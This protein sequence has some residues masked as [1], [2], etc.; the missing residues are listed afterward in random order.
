[1]KLHLGCGKRYIPGFFHMDAVPFAHL[2]QQGDIRNL[3]FLASESVDLIYCC[4][5]FEY[6]D[7]DEARLTLREWRRVLKP[8]GVLRLAVPD[9]EALAELYLELRDLSRVLGP[10]YGRIAANDG[11]FFHK[12]A[13]DFATLRQILAEEGFPGGDRY[14]WRAVEHSSVDDFSQAYYPHMEKNHGKLLSLNVEAR[15]G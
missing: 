3:S 13:Y 7:V 10:I 8:G 6:F 4:H 9:F 5:A 2:D 15:K 12:T 1:M 14:D 11:F